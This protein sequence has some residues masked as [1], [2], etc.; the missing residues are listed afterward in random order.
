MSKIQGFVLK[1]PATWWAHFHN[2]K[3]F[4]CIFL[5]VPRFLHRKCTGFWMSYTSG[6]SRNYSGCRQCAPA[7]THRN[8]RLRWELEQ[9]DEDLVYLEDWG[10]TF[11]RNVGSC[12]I[13]TAP[14]PRRRHSSWLQLI[15]QLQSVHGRSWL[16]ISRFPILL[17]LV[18]GQGCVW[19]VPLTGL[20]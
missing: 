8:S 11:L 4:T 3:I 5:Y 10:D 17:A 15:S 14:H 18:G 1:Q 12:R 20:H 16:L 9:V 6:V 2:T 7:F 19:D 13:Y